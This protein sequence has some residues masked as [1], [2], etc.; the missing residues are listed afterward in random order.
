MAQ[1]FEWDENKNRANRQR[2]GISFEEA[3]AIFEGPVFTAQDIR[4]DYGEERFI[5][6]G[7]IGNTAG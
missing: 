7:M 5:S 6:I 4:M 3:Q 2:H 1:L